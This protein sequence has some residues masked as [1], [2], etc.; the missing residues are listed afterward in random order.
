MTHRT[1]Q[2]LIQLTKDL[3]GIESVADKPAEIR[4]AY[5]FV[6]AMIKTCGKD[7]TIEEFEQNGSPS[8]LAYRGLHRPDKFS[9][10]FTGHLDVVPGKKEQY[11]ATE[12]SGKLYGRGTTDMKAAAVILTDVF[13]E[14]VDKV[15][16]AL[17]LQMSCDEELGSSNGVEYQVAQGVRSG[18]VICGGCGRLPDTYEIANAAKVSPSP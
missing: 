15:P 6:I 9:L 16:Y 10:M 1:D 7:I 2:Q 14:F 12:K 3:I 4:K 11:V 17:G 8:F 18:L 5:D 13:C